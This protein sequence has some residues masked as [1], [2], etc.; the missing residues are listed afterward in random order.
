M[1]TT[2]GLSR[3]A[4]AVYRCLRIRTSSHDSPFKRLLLGMDELTAKTFKFK[5]YHPKN[6]ANRSYP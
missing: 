1:Q 4:P 3:I 6:L 2:D 5:S